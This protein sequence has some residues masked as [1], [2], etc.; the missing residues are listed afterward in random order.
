[1]SEKGY[2]VLISLIKNNYK[3]I[4]GF[5]Y[6]KP[7]KNVQKDYFEEIKNLCLTNNILFINSENNEIPCDFYIAISW[8][9]IIKDKSN[10]IILHDSLL[11]KYRGFSP[12]VNALINGEKETG[13]T[14]IFARQKYDEGPIIIQKK[15]D[16]KYPIKIKEAITL[17]S[18][19]YN[20][21]ALII[22]DKIKKN[23]RIVAKEQK[24]SD[25]TYSLWREEKDYHID[26]NMS[27]CSIKR[28]IDA[29]GYPYSGAYSIIE[30]TKVRIFNVEELLDVNIPL[31]QSGKIIYFEKDAP[32]VVCGKGLLKILEIRNEKK[33]LYKHLK[34]RT[35]FQ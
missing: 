22:F 26:W 2:N 3:E 15:I 34:F 19:L 14:A 13:V 35:V 27:A 11:P 25:A 6:S 12:L 18:I 9:Q 17:I 29:V 16:I 8:R 23:E 24:H 31:R 33:E 30:N 32:V 5:V 21:I 1:M 20:E 10:L 4:I 7:D 28:F